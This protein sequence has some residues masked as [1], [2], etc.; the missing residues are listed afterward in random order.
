MIISNCL[1]GFWS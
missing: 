1:K